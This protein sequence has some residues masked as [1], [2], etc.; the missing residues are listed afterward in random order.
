MNYKRKQNNILTYF[1]LILGVLLI[2]LP[3]YVTVVTALKSNEQSAQSF[4]SLPIPIYLESF[5]EVLFSEK[6]YRALMN[7]VYITAIVLF[8]NVLIMP[9]MSYAVARR[10]PRSRW[11]RYVYFFL[12]LGIFIPFQVKMMPLVKMLSSLDMMNP[13][14]LAILC[15]SSSTCESVFLFVGYMGAI[16]VDM[17]EAAQIDGASTFLTYRAIVFP[18]LKPMMATVLIKQGLWIW[19]DF[20]LPLI[21]L[22]RSWED[23]TLTLFQY[24]FQTE[25][26]I[27]YS[28]TFATFVVS[29]MPLIIFYCF[30][31]KMIIGGLTTGAVKS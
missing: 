5:K 28:L 4:F 16:P 23:W 13:T 31:Q 9:A 29:M 17:E 8:G 1:I 15:I 21:T 19:N 26:S 14:G 10:M 30:M 11:Y 22:N 7:T 24:N 25:Y 18:L 20:M 2:I 3:L 6:Y 12:L 27:N